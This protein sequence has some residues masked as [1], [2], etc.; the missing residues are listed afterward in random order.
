MS[1]LGNKRTN[2]DA[3]PAAKRHEGEGKQIPFQT[4]KSALVLYDIKPHMIEIIKNCVDTID[5]ELEV[6]PEILIFGKV[7]RQR[8]NVG[9]YS[10]TSVGYRYSNRVMASKP[11]HQCLLE[12]LN[13]VNEKFNYNYNG[14]L[15]NKY[16]G[17]DDYISAHSDDERGLDQKV[18]VVSI[19]YGVSRKFRV[20]HKVGKHIAYDLPTDSTK[21]MQMAGDFQKEFTH[22]IVK[23][24][25]IA[26][27]R[28]SFTFRHHL[29]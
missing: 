25:E 13:Y 23:E 29:T 26:G 27:D 12:L 9:F 11:L 19:S 17:G 7:A 10:N 22:E 6:Q 5:S 28:Y 20:R 24:S 18:G 16:V 15:I 8:R 1:I 2:E 4:E 3:A 21:I 14:I